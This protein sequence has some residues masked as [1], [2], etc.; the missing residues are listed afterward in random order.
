MP[1]Y[2][3]GETFDLASAYSAAQN[4]KESKQNMELRGLQIQ[5]ARKKLNTPAEVSYEDAIGHARLANGAAYSVIADPSDTNVIRQHDILQRTGSLSPEFDLKAVLALPPEQRIEGAKRWVAELEPFLKN[6]VAP[7]KGAKDESGIGNID[8][9]KVT[10]ESLA[11]FKKTGDYG[12]LAFRKPEGSDGPAAIQE[13]EYFNALPPDQKRAFLEV[14][15]NPAFSIQQIAGVPTGVGTLPG[16]G[17]QTTPLSTLPSEVNAASQLAGGTE[18]GKLDAQRSQKIAVALKNTKSS[19]ELLDLASSLARIATGSTVGAG[20]DFV[21]N[22]FGFAPRGDEAISSL[23]AIGAQL[24]LLVPRM[25]GPQSDKDT[26]LYR[27][28]AGDIA[29][30]TTPAGKKLASIRTVRQLNEKYRALNPQ[31]TQSGTGGSSQTLRFDAQ[32]NQLP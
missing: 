12:V 32:G 21:A 7:E 28:A 26:A 19:D 29:S 20:V 18:A 5:D 24:A 3:L 13:Y 9:S 4:I 1:S 2:Q 23:Q 8:P 30:A 15:R 16:G 14:K 11:R 25:E 17:I 31:P 6:A 27:Q 10:P 22:V